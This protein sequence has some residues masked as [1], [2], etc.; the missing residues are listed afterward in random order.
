MN[1]AMNSPPTM[2]HPR[3]QAVLLEEVVAALSPK[4]GEVYVDA[5]AGLGGHAAV[6]APRLCPGGTVVLNDVD[7]G[8]LALAEAKVRALVGVGG[9]PRVVAIQ[10]NFS[11]LARRMPAGLKADMVLADLGFSSNQIEEASRGF[12][13]MRDG[14]L[15]MRL[16][17]T[18]AVS[19]RDLVA[20]LSEGELASIIR[21]FGEDPGAKRIARKVIEARRRSP[22]QTTLQLSAIIRQAVGPGRRSGIDPAT[23]TFQA[24]RIAVNDELGSLDAWLASVERGAMGLVRETNEGRAGMKRNTPGAGAWLNP[25]AR[26]GVISFHSMEDRRVKQTF[27]RLVGRGAAREFSR[28]PIEA[29]EAELLSNPR[30]RSAKLRAIELRTDLV[31]S[32]LG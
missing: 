2:S 11:E 1:K 13:F 17:P 20:S 22:I 16:D 8:N 18:L 27:A 15:D 25:G 5:T 9:V 7:P 21:D 14:P 23:R 3:H 24:L 29:G 26:I 32:E 28:R 12:S 31:P 19:A 10:G 6:I 4:A 30:S